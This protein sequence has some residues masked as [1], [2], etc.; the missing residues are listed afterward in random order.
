VYGFAAGMMYR[1]LPKKTDMLY[2]GINIY[3]SLIT[4]MLAGR[5]VGGLVMW[6]VLTNADSAY[7]LNAFLTA[8]FVTP[9]LGII[10]HLIIIPS[11]VISLRKAKLL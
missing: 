7:S 8:Y 1:M 4:A 11:I 5:V 6:R 3:A 9:I 10:I 2:D